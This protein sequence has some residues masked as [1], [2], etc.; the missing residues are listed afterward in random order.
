D[1]FPGHQRQG[2][3]GVLDE[4]KR[5]IL[6]TSGQDNGLTMFRDAMAESLIAHT[7]IDTLAYRPAV[8]FLNGEYWGIHNIRERYDHHY[9][10]TN[11]EVEDEDVVILQGNVEVV[12]GDPGDDLSYRQMLQ[13]IANS[14]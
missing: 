1:I 3:G 5:L 6:H 10:A 14:A 4:F 7:G 9:V 8:V 11:Y 13:F 2:G 12:A